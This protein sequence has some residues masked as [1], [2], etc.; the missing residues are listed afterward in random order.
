MRTSMVTEFFGIDASQI[1][2]FKIQYKSRTY[3][4]SRTTADAYATI[5]FADVFDT[6]GFDASA[7]TEL[8]FIF[9]SNVQ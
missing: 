9:T 8:T 5:S 6:I 3:T 4:V 1:A 2:S 7:S